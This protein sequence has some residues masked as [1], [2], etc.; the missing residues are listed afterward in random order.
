MEASLTTNCSCQALLAG[1]ESALPQDGHRGRPCF[2]Q[3]NHSKARDGGIIDGTHGNHCKAVH[4]GISH[5][6]HGSCCK[7]GM[8]GLVTS[9]TQRDA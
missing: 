2:M 1:L 4:G 9:L 3:G 5:S 6:N 8:M 7:E